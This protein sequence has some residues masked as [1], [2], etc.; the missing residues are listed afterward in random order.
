MQNNEGYSVKQQITD[1]VM[2]LMAEKNYME[3][4]V[5][6]VINKAGVARASFY[7]NFNTISDVIDLTIDKISMEFM[8][9]VLPVLTGNDKKMWREFLFN[10][11]YR[12][13]KIKKEMKEIRFENLSVIFTRLNNKIIQKEE[14]IKHSIRDRYIISAKNPGF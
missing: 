2:E 11:F 5:S 10:Y 3:I 12:M 6:D 13:S 7:R 4:T 1:A 8:E 9:D 14:T